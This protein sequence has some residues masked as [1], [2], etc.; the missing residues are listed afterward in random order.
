MAWDQTDAS[1]VRDR[2]RTVWAVARH[3]G[4]WGW[5]IRL[6]CGTACRMER[7]AH[8]RA[9]AQPAGWRGWHIRLSCGMAFRMEMAHQ[10]ELWHGLQ[11][12]GWHI[13]Q[14]W[15]GLQDG[16]DGTSHWA[17]AQPAGW[18]GWHIKL[19]CGTAFTMED[20]TSDWTVARP[21]GWR[22][23][24]ICFAL[25]NLRIQILALRWLKSFRFATL[26]TETFVK[27]SDT[28][29]CVVVWLMPDVSKEHFAFLVHLTTTNESI[30][31]LRNVVTTH[32]KQQRRVSETLNP[33]ADRC[34]S[35][36]LFTVLNDVTSRRSPLCLW[37]CAV[38]MH[39][40]RRVRIWPGSSDEPLRSAHKTV[41]HVV[42]NDNLDINSQW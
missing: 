11:D 32:P 28:G 4:W 9:V 26:K 5:H 27:C 6:N 41:H 12:G 42:I 20:G 30:T 13:R 2:R 24:H 33:P 18:R 38:P 14:L 22:G 25:W 40:S 1:E 39:A 35:L 15:H 8:Q 21:A 19:S 31:L 16:N 37:T 34:V 10:T 17:V 23:W 29:R 7:M 36:C 3:W